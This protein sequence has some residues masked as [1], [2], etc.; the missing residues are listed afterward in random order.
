M[1]EK[2]DNGSNSGSPWI[3]DK[4][5]GISVHG[6]FFG[7]GLL[8]VKPLGGNSLHATQRMAENSPTDRVTP[9]SFTF[10][11]RELC[12]PH[13]NDLV[14]PK[15]FRKVQTLSQAF[16]DQRKSEFKDKQH[17]LTFSAENVIFNRKRRDE[18][19]F[20]FTVRQANQ[21]DDSIY[22]HPWLSITDPNFT[23]G[24][25]SCYTTAACLFGA[26]LEGIDQYGGRLQLIKHDHKF[27]WR[28]NNR[29]RIHRT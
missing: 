14:N 3:K 22:I 12:Y 15:A 18:I 23:P 5:S 1:F 27:F 9:H 11:D 13:G 25:F 10:R 19:F 7:R 24:C 16:L 20:P 2:F 26:N 6:G 28:S 21:A 4:T 8:V 17:S 29:K